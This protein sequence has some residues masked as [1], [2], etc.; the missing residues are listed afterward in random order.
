VTSPAPPSQQNDIKAVLAAAIGSTCVGFVPYF[1]SGL[2]KTGVD[3]VSVL[4]FRYCIALVLLLPLA[5]WRTRGLVEEWQAGGRWLF[6]N[7]VTL[8]A[9]QTY[10]YFKAI[11][12]IATSIVVTTFYCYPIITIV[13]DRYVFKLR[14]PWTTIAALGVVLIGV[15]LTS[16]PGFAG[17][18]ID[19]AGLTY[20]M[21]TAVGYAVYIAVAYPYTRQVSALASATFIYASM[22][23]A[24]G[25][26]VLYRGLQLPP[27]PHLW[28][29]L[30]AIGTLGGALQIASFAYALPRLSSSGYAIVVCLELVTVVLVGV[31]L[32]G[33]HLVLAQWLGVVL[34]LG[35]ILIERIAKARSA[36]A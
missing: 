32:L 4:L 19:P 31:A 7:G 29:N 28:L 14:V 1:V 34:V 27:E 12:T 15:L 9:F 36:S 18:A 24:F 22:A 6:L 33:E 25:A 17:A 10:C 21:L 5:L 26:A 2:Q 20:A 30:I 35:G 3:T 16:L 11:E 23:T 8:G 13:I